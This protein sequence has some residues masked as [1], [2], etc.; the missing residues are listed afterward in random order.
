MHYYIN[1]YPNKRLCHNQTHILSYYGRTANAYFSSQIYLISKTG[2]IFIIRGCVSNIS[3]IGLIRWKKIM[4]MLDY[5]T[6]TKSVNQAC[7]PFY[8]ALIFQYDRITPITDILRIR[9]TET[10]TLCHYVIFYSDWI[11]A[12][13]FDSL[14]SLNF[15]NLCLY[16][17]WMKQ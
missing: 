2:T 1:R 14:T 11:K 15:L 4:M 7:Y 6:V 10:R 17:Q 16:R 5:L 3:N 8:I 9:F 12:N 13:S